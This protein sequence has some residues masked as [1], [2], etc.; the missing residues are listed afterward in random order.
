MLLELTSQVRLLQ[1]K[2]SSSSFFFAVVLHHCDCKLVVPSV[3]LLLLVRYV[4]KTIKVRCYETVTDTV[5]QQAKVKIPLSL[6]AIC[7]GNRKSVAHNHIGFPR[8]LHGSNSTRK[9]TASMCVLLLRVWW[10]TKHA[11]GF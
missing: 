10:K 9:K 11:Y 8:A 6:P 4:G 2:L 5:E 7:T 1:F 3:L